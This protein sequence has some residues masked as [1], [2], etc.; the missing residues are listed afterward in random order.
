MS[1]IL[2]S[3]RIGPVPVAVILR[4][5]HRASLGITEH[6]IETGAKVT[7]HAYLEAKR[8]SL[9]FADNHAADAYN[10]LVRFQSDR[11]PFTIVSGLFVYQNMLIKDLSAERDSE[12]SKILRGRAELQ[13]A[14]IVSTAYTVSEANLKSGKPGGKNSSQAAR[15]TPDKAKDEQTKDRASGTVVRGDAAEKA[16]DK[17]ILKGWLGQ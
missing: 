2:F 8:L 15:P 11:V 12:N 5:R 1:A 14:I 17:S 9:E 16:A 6:P 3:G 13:E 10:A 7:D 4:E